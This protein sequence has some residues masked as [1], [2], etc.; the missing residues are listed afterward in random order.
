MRHFIFLATLAFA[1][2]ANAASEYIRCSEN[3]NQ[4]I[5]LIAFNSDGG[6]ANIKYKNVLFQNVKYSKDA[7]LGFEAFFLSRFG[8]QEEIKLLL[9]RNLPTNSTQ[10]NQFRG[11]TLVA[12]NSPAWSPL[13]DLNVD[14]SCGL[15]KWPDMNVE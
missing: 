10:P 5:V 3:S 7:D 14:L 13:A 12:R 9:F 4:Q 15:E 1:L 8:T 2:N 6:S 11:L